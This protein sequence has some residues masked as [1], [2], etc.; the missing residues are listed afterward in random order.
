L[1]PYPLW[2]RKPIKKTQLT[3]RGFN[4]PDAEDALDDDSPQ[5]P[6][7]KIKEP[8]QDNTPRSLQQEVKKPEQEDPP[9]SPQRGGGKADEFHAISLVSGFVGGR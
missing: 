5:S 4:A 8:E 7:Q 1:W 3:L 2:H 6:Q 9:L